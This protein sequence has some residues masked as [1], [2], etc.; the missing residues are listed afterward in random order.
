MRSSAASPF[1]PI[2]ELPRTLFAPPR[3]VLAMFVAARILLSFHGMSRYKND[4]DRSGGVRYVDREFS[5]KMRVHSFLWLHEVVEG[6]LKY[7]AVQYPCPS[8]VSM[9]GF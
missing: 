7:V 3:C 1:G 2:Y 6:V 9:K 4:C 8:P 5:S